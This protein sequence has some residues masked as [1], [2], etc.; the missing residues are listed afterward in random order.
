MRRITDIQTASMPLNRD[1]CQLNHNKISTKF[2]F[3]GTHTILGY[4]F[5]FTPK[6]QKHQRLRRNNPI[7]RIRART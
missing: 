2:N 4:S 6:I 3:I 7:E 1:K 5:L